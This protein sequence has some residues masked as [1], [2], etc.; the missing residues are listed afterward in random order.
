MSYGAFEKRG[1]FL[2][3]EEKFRRRACGSCIHKDACAGW[4]FDTGL[5]LYKYIA[6]DDVYRCASYV[7][8]K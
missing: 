3:D 7:P 1:I 4:E 6:K 2:R 5:T 8:A